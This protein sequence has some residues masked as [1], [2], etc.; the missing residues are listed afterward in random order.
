MN[1]KAFTLIELLVVVL[2]IGILA[3]IALPQYE[4]AVE[5]SR[6]AEAF[7]ISKTLQQAIDVWIL[8]NGFPTSEIEFLG[9][10]AD[11]NLSVELPNDFDCSL[12]EGTAC[13]GKNF[14]YKAYCNSAG[15]TMWLSRI[16]GTYSL[17]LSR[18][19][20]GNTWYPGDCGYYPD[21]GAIG[22]K[23]CNHLRTQDFHPCQNC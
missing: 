17:D 13:G 20:S 19:I 10:N 21:A 18:N 1:K 23:M 14:S 4:L 6:L 2:I 5:K 3:A 22:E 8:E 9:D 16:N 15:C 12:V 7:T 11:E